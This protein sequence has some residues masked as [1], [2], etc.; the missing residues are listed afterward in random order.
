MTSSSPL[1]VDASGPVLVATINRPESHNALNSEVLEQI[2][3]VVHD[4][5]RDGGVRAVVVTGSGDRAFSAG[6]DLREL[7]GMTPDEAYA[8]IARGQAAMRTIERAT[9]PVI[10]AVN[11]LALGG[12]MELALA[13]TFPVLSERATLALPESGLGLI[14]G[15]GGTQRLPR[16]I[17]ERVAAY[18]MLT[19]SRIGALRA[20]ELGMTP[21]PPVAP[22]LLLAS[23]IEIAG[24]IAAKGPAATRSILRAIEFGRDATLDSGLE[25]EAGLAALAIA[26]TESDEGIDAYLGRRTPNFG[27]TDGAL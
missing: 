23:A 14:P 22:E 5:E 16:A 24:Q 12:G 6:A 8:V 11:G 26:G 3:D 19:G 17:G 15:Y 20:Y 27:G 2:Q 25:L 13:A 10:T 4:A 21:V 18:L 1:L 7:A 9:I